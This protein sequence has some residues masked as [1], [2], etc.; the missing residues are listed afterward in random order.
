MGQKLATPQT[1][2]AFKSGAYGFGVH[3]TKNHEK[4]A[5]I[6]LATK[7]D[8]GTILKLITD[9]AIYEKEPVS[10]VE[11]TEAELVRDGWGPSPLFRVVLAEVGGAAVGFALFFHT[12]STWQGKCVYLEDLYVAEAA[13]GAGVGTLLLK[14]VAA[15]AH[16]EGCKRFNWQ[17][18]DWNTPA[19]DFYKALGAA[20]MDSWVNLR[21]GKAELPRLLGL[22]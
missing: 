20:R 17:A 9:L 14:T 21:V 10:T 1:T 2:C 19:L 4:L 8:A 5:T 3:T 16:G 18:L 12:Y 6:R 22:S 13:R 11:V 15:I 7:D